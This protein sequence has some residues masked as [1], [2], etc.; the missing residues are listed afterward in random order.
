MINSIET[1]G[2]EFSGYFHFEFKYPA[3]RQNRFHFMCHDFI[4]HMHSVINA[5]KP[6]NISIFIDRIDERTTSLQI[7]SFGR[8]LKISTNTVDRVNEILTFINLS[9]IKPLFGDEAEIIL[10]LVTK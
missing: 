4:E 1:E 9:K 8:E 3:Q 10:R 5:P 7:P 6:R 2:D